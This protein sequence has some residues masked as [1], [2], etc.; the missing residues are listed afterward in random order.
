MPFPFSFSGIVQADADGADGRSDFARSLVRALTEEG[1]REVFQID[2]R[3]TFRGITGY[4]TLS[5]LVNI[6][7]GILVL[8]SGAIAYDIAFDR[9]LLFGCLLVPFMGVVF[10]VV[11][12]PVT[13]VGSCLGF[14]AIPFG[15]FY[16]VR[17]RFR[18]WLGQTARQIAKT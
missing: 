7:R 10:W 13:F 16:W 9:W 14:V 18:R 5:P 6:E 15:G 12:A 2:N 4:R 11:G 3:I 8:S 17:S 1:G